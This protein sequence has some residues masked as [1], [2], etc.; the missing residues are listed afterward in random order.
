M[1]KDFATIDFETYYAKDFT[2]SKLQT[3]EYILDD[4]F[5]I[6]GV[7]AK[8]GR[9]A[10]TE[11]YSGT[12]KHVKEFLQDT[13]DWENT[14]VCAHHAHFDGFIA[15][16]RL[17]LYPKMW[18]DTLSM[19]RMHYP[20]WKS[21][22]L[23]N[24]AQELGLGQKGR[25]VHNYTG[26]RRGDFNK[27]Q[28][29]DYGNYCDN[30]VALTHMLAELLLERT[31]LL[32]L[33]LIDMTIRMFTE[34]QLYGDTDRLIKYYEGEVARKENL[35][36][37]ANVDKKDLMSNPKFA[38]LLEDRFV[39]PPMKTSKTTGKQ[40]YAFAKSDK[41]FTA[42]L[43]HPDEEVQVLV[44]ARLGVKSSIAETRA[45]RFVHTSQR[46]AMPVYLAHWGAKTTGRLSGGNK[47]NWQNIPARGTAKELRN[48]IVAPDGYK[49]VVGDSSN[50]ELRLAMVMAGQ[51]DQVLKVRA[52][53]ALGDAA[54]SDLY[55]DFST[56]LHGRVITKEKKDY[57]ER[58]LGKV[59]MLSLQYQSGYVTF[60]E[61]VRTMAQMAITEKEAKRIVDMYRMTF[62]KLPEM[63]N[64]CGDIILQAIHNGDKMVSVDK[65]GW[66]Q[67]TSNG[68]ALLG[69]PGVVYKNLRKNNEGD[70][71]Y[72]MGRSEVKIYGGKVLENLCQHA[73]RQIVMWQTAVVNREYPVAL[74]VHDE[75]VCVVPEDDAEECKR[76]M[77]RALSLA[78]KWCRGEI[79]LAGEVAI[80]DS[81]GEAK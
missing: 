42:L 47:M 26:F 14:P 23:A 60:M 70:W 8:A 30:D 56:K 79:P 69:S 10:R 66:F 41:N 68:F 46:G 18:L 76:Y 9:N 20:W 6:I 11:W 64:Y 1:I 21:H 55:C 49:V 39:I 29:A 34:P 51:K 57:T 7:S 81:Y 53:D 71:V 78:P 22:S 72:D 74:S 15:S 44:A 19:A 16:Q 75:M 59:A 77:E 33:I 80:G 25:Q 5:E 4:R 32:E 65:E 36:N 17:E 40:T 12:E 61:M 35:L 50:I 37:E 73:G 48:C 28:L 43:D 62:D 3:D 67:T 63:W 54:T 2:L 13:I 38:K 27:A 45:L 58:L 52:Y 24:I 31:P